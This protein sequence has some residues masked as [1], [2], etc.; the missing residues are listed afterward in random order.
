MKKSKLTKEQMALVFKARY[1]EKEMAR[2][3][4]PSH[5]R[6]TYRF[7][8]STKPYS[9]SV[10]LPHGIGDM[11]VPGYE[12]GFSAFEKGRWIYKLIFAHQAVSTKNSPAGISES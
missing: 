4:T 7:S 8:S 1:R 3:S 10:R 9:A 5:C 2:Y 6:T 12:T 11:P